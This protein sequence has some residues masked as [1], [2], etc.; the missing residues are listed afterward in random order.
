MAAKSVGDKFSTANG[1]PE[2]NGWPGRNTKRD[3]ESLMTYST[4]GSAKRV[5][6]GTTAAPDAEI[7]QAAGE[8]RR[9]IPQFAVVDAFAADFYDSFRGW[10]LIH[11]VAQHFQQRVRAS[12]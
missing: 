2:G 12:V 11:C 7:L 6:T 1:S 3:P 10:R 9:A 8:A 4:S 5:F